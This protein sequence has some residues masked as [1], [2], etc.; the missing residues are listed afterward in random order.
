MAA[1]PYRFKPY[2]LKS[3]STMLT[4]TETG[5]HQ[6]KIEGYSFNKGIGIGKWLTSAIFTIGGYDWAIKYFPDGE[7]EETKDYL[8]CFLE[9]RS[10]ATVKA[11]F[12]IA[13][14]DQSKPSGMSLSL[15]QLKYHLLTW[16]SNFIVYW[17]VVKEQM[18][19]SKLVGKFSEPINS[20]LE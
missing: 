15:S 16:T 7:T 18:L 12:G 2:V 17:R 13:L 14:L 5:Y 9:L 11:S 10:E 19:V 1:K 6:F 8:A 3:A 20:Y 4:E